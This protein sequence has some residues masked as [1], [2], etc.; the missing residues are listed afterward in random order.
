[1]AAIGENHRKALP[2]KDKPKP[3]T[4]FKYTA[5]IHCFNKGHAKSTSPPLDHPRDLRH[6]L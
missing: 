6:A 4:A 1:L 5:L 3:P 2:K